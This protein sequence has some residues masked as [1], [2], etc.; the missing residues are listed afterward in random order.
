L[1]HFSKEKEVDVPES[2]PPLNFNAETSN[3]KEHLLIPQMIEV[4]EHPYEYLIVKTQEIHFKSFTLNGNEVDAFSVERDLGLCPPM[5]DYLV[6]RH[7]EIRMA[8]LKAHS[9]QFP[10]PYYPLSGPENHPRHF[11]ASWFTQFSSW[12]EYSPTTDVTYC[13]LCYL[14]AMKSVGCLGWDVFI[15]KGF[16][17]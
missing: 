13:L 11:K 8:Y 1:S 12:L 3:L 4:E 9:Y 7:D 2:N 14:F 10:H 15:T 6:N 17:N 16:R 5:W